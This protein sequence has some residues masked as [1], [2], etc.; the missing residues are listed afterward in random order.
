MYIKRIQVEEGFLSGLD[1]T[2]SPGL[3][4]LIG[5]RGTGKTSIIE[6]VRYCLSSSSLTEAAGAKAIEHARAVLGPGVVTV[7][8]EVGAQ[9]FTISRSRDGNSASVSSPV[10]AT[11]LSQNEIEL[12]GL[13]AT[14]RLR[15]I[16]SFRIGNEKIRARANAL[17][18]EARSLTVEARGLWQRIEA[19]VEQIAKLETESHGLELLERDQRNSVA[20]LAGSES[21]QKALDELSREIAQLSV[22]A[23][24]YERVDRELKEWFE[25]VSVA[26]V[27]ARIEP[28]P[29]AAGLEDQLVQVRQISRDVSRQIASVLQEI[30]RARRDLLHLQ[31]SVMNARSQ[32]ETQ[33]RALRTELESLKEG[34][35]ALAR[36]VTELR[37]KAG[38][39]AALRSVHGDLVQRRNA[40]LGRRDRILDEIDE[41][42]QTEFNERQEVAKRLNSEL[43]P[44][45]HVR[46]ER[47]GLPSS[48]VDALR[49]VLRGSGMRYNQLAPQIAERLS[50]RELTSAVERQD[51]NTIA[52][53]AKISID[54]AAR[55]IAE[56]ARTGAEDVVTCELEDTVILSLLDGKDYKN[57][58]QLSTGQRCTVVLPLLL[59]HR[60]DLLIIDQPEDHLDNAFIVETAVKAIRRRSEQGQL[61]ISTHNPNIPVLGAAETVVLLGSDGRRGF[62]RQAAPLD[63]PASVEAIT[64]V[65]E[66]GLE[67]F[68]RRSQFYESLNP[69]S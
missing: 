66:G 24:I 18:S 2:L 31:T 67:A 20:A 16:D 61:V 23:A 46:V 25:R 56:L 14:G 63:D 5:P 62:V 7:T 38:Q 50:P 37:E 8:L 21:K 65:M 44:R 43:G 52:D 39:A 49:G 10:A 27:P 30:D 1:L 47:A 64:N 35:G 4:V 53:I 32:S 57:T 34:S 55:L 42:C 45:I 68:R 51:P 13:N 33:A 69:E 19:T 11:I 26:E 48:Y 3:N 59:S 22:R 17:R 41:V 29:E 60:D 36:R 15:L 6:L 9:Q 40:V 58:E 54:R 28:W 12:V